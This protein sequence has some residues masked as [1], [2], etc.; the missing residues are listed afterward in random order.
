MRLIRIPFAL[1]LTGFVMLNA[2]C[3]V[4]NQVV[5]TVDQSGGKLTTDQVAQGLKE[6]LKVGTDVAV[7]K[8]NATDGYYL[9]QIVKILLPPE[10]QELVTYARKV[11]GMDKLISDVVLQINRSAED[12]AKQAAP[13][14]VN[15]IT[16]MTIG[17]AWGILNGADTAATGYLREK[18][19]A[20]LFNLY[21]PSV[22][23]SLDKPI[24]AGV[25]ANQSW[26]QLTKN[27][28]QFA[29]SIAGK[30]LSVKQI[31]YTLDEYVT[32]QALRGLFIKVKD[33]EKLIRTDINART[34]DLLRRV[35]GNR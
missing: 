24:V 21:R 23:N 6:A 15:A 1:I 29:G 11:P 18:T 35:F 32:K 10:T 13:I 17:D 14:F 27:W 28:N 2:S 9:D 16:S 26:N 7:K 34:S 12:A 30:L 8:L 5:T 19:F 31:N 25:S 22:K 4:L 3:D 20:Q 33:Q